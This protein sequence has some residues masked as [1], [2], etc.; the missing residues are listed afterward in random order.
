MVALRLQGPLSGNG[1]GRVEVFY[2]GQW[3][4][5]C[6]NNWNLRDARVA[7]RELGYKYALRALQGSEVPDGTGKIWLNNVVCTGSEPSLASC[8]HWGWENHNCGHSMDAGVECSN[9][10][11]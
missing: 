6:D 3:G 2:G 10:R 7:C 4:T 1:T 9:G 11:I 8:S 5:I